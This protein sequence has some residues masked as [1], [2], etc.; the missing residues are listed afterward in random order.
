[1]HG[2]EKD[3]EK[4]IEVQHD[5]LRQVK[6]KAYLISSSISASRLIF[7][8]MFQHEESDTLYCYF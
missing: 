1:M 3:E 4:G 6:K 5:Y 7:Y 8:S 2:L